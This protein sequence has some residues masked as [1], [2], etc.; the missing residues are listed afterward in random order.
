MSL[1]LAQLTAPQTVDQ[2]RQL[3][4]SSLQGV[5][6]VTK[7]T[8]NGTGSLSASGTP[9]AAYSIV[10]TIYAAGELGA[11][12]FR[13]S[14]DG[15]STSSA[16]T[17]L[18]G[19]YS[20]PGTGITLTFTAGPT[21]AGTS[22]SGDV[23]TF[24]ATVPSFPV[25]AW[26]VGSAG[27]SLAEF[28][29]QFLSDMTY[30]LQQIA[31]GGLID[32]WINPPSPPIPDAWLDLLAA[33]VYK[34]TR[35]PAIAAEGTE[36]ITDT[37]S[38]GPFNIAIGQLTFAATSGQLYTNTS[39]GTLTKGGSLAVTVRAVSPG[40]AY[41]VASGTITSIT[42]G[43]LPGV[44]CTNPVGWLS[45]SGTDAETSLALALRCQGRWP[46]IGIGATS[47]TYE[48]WARTATSNVARVLVLPDPTVPGQ[49][50]VYIAGAA[51]PVAGGDVTTV[52]NYI[53]ARV[54]TTC[55]ALVSNCASQVN[56][57]AAT[58]KVRA[59]S[60]AAAAVSVPL[61][62]AAYI[63][64]IGISDGTAVVSYDMVIAMLGSA[65]G[66]IDVSSV[67]LNG[68]AVNIGPLALGQLPIVGSVT[69]TW[70]QV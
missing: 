70:I 6:V 31:G 4:F 13:Y 46:S 61:A 34:L 30:L 2:L 11:A 17:A 24:P 33:S 26:Q 28:D 14:L 44:T 50:D 12:T 58:I 64:G 18:P 63:N 53:N 56:N 57:V 35:N 45:T 52:Q 54:P 10:V 38:A 48:Y 36:N 32:S 43:A 49:T 55:T 65:P 69:L 29:A 37:A 39:G 67:L 25:T 8:G 1:T 16:P 23:W 19:I 15:G 68:A 20:I 27:R 59:A 5:G 51:A 22:F 3:L 21:G 41:N 9:N 47:A 40:A 62:L 66:T 60:Y 7:T 42:A